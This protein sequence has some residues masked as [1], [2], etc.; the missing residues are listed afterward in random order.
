MRPAQPLRKPPLVTVGWLG[1]T[2]LPGG[3]F[4]HQTSLE[5]H[6]LIADHHPAIGT[7]LFGTSV[8]RLPQPLLEL[9]GRGTADSKNVMTRVFRSCPSVITEAASEGKSRP[10]AGGKSH[11]ASV[12][13]MWDDGARSAPAW[14]NGSITRLTRS[15]RFAMVSPPGT[16]HS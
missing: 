5:W 8:C 2:V 16:P 13:S 3:E 11:A 7:N 14:R 6:R 1:V 15:A 12:R 10:A 4:L 9:D